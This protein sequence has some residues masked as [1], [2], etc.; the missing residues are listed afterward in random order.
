M[1]PRR[2]LVARWRVFPDDNI[3]ITFLLSVGL[4]RYAPL[5]LMAS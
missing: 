5:F 4:F 3:V 1:V 2:K